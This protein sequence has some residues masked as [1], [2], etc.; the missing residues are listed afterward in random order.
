MRPGN[1]RFDT[2][3]SVR[4]RRRQPLHP[5]CFRATGRA[6]KSS[7]R[8]LQ[9]RSLL[10]LRDIAHAPRTAAKCWRSAVLDVT[11]R[12]AFLR[13]QLSR[14]Q[15]V[16]CDARRLSYF[17]SDLRRF[18]VNQIVSEARGAWQCRFH[19]AGSFLC[20]PFIKQVLGLFGSFR[21]GSRHPDFGQRVVNVGALRPSTADDCVSRNCTP[22]RHAFRSSRRRTQEGSLRDVKLNPVLESRVTPCI[23]EHTHF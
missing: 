20:S 17:R 6:T 8:R 19:G 3:A 21:V 2:P 13:R 22:A 18:P 12:S 10:R 9:G 4:V 15:Q 5:D 7:G 16:V 14:P 1:P 23:R 11:H